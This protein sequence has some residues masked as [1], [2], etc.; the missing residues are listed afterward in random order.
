[1]PEAI[2]GKSFTFQVLFVDA[3]SNPMTPNNP[4]ISVFKFSQAGARE[5]LIVDQV[6]VPVVPA[7]VGRYTYTYQIASPLDAGDVLYAEMRGTDPDDFVMTVEQEV[8]VVS[9]VTFSGGGGITARF[10]RN[11]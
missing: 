11:P 6:M 2:L 7:E 5:D 8:T 3:L 9:P 10:V 4:R 1:M